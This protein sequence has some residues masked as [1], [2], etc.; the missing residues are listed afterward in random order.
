MRSLSFFFC[1]VFFLFFP[2]FSPFLDERLKSDDGGN[3]PDPQFSPQYD[4]AGPLRYLLCMLSQNTGANRRTGVANSNPL[5]ST[6]LS[7]STKELLLV[8]AAVAAIERD[9]EANWV[10]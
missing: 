9:Q 6:K 8:A 2:F 5:A 3:S 10:I 1:L 4:V 7:D